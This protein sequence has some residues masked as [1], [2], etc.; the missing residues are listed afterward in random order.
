MT[1]LR[2]S[3]GDGHEPGPELELDARFEGG[4]PQD[5]AW[6]ARAP[7]AP[8]LPDGVVD[9]PVVVTVLDGPHAGERAEGVVDAAGDE[10]V[11]RGTSGFTEPASPTGA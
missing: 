2:V 4:E 3:H 10:L 8:G 5:D 6:V 11:L 7:T 9:G 1:K